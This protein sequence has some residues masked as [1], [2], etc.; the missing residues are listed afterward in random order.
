MVTL[1][2]QGDL[3]TEQT[4]KRRRVGII[5]GIHQRQVTVVFLNGVTTMMIRMLA[6]ST[7][8]GSLN[9]C[10]YVNVDFHFIAKRH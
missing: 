7:P 9:L 6:H 1:P 8:Q 4:V 10:G 3:G 5:G 2:L